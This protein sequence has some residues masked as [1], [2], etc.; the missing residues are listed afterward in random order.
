MTLCPNGKNIFPFIMAIA[1][2]AMLAFGGTYAYF[3]A[4]TENMTGQLKTGTVKLTTT[5]TAT[6]AFTANVLPGDSLIKS[7]IEYAVETTD[8][9]GNYVT[10]RVELTS[11]ATGFVGAVM[12]EG[13]TVGTGWTEISCSDGV[14]IFYKKV[15]SGE[16][17]T[18]EAAN[19]VLP[20]SFG[21]EANQAPTAAALMNADFT[22]K[23]QAKSIQASHIASD[24]VETT[25][26]S[27]WA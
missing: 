27:M 11:D 16:A 14:G 22:I 21:G 5:A 10:V 17:A 6:T 25:I 9:Q 2:V 4:A 3:T 26:Q 18:L 8:A 7:D 13:F 23:I 12:A 20:V 19:F 15:N 1:M 24:A